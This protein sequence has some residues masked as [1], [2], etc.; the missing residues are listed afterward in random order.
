MGALRWVSNMVCILAA[1]SGCAV[2]PYS[3]PE[4]MAEHQRKRIA[5]LAKLYPP[6]TPRDRLLAEYPPRGESGSKRIYYQETF[7]LPLASPVVSHGHQLFRGI[8]EHDLP[9]MVAAARLLC[10]TEPTRV[11]VFMA[12]VG[13]LYLGTDGHYVFYDDQDHVL[14]T[15][16]SQWTD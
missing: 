9:H 15:L 3:S 16:G 13:T 5:Y 14:I 1:L 7:T 2:S 4:D 11:D 12:S 6:D 10:S 8:V